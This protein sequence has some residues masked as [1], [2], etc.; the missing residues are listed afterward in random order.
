MDKSL[1]IAV[2]SKE[3]WDRFRMIIGPYLPLMTYSVAAVQLHQSG[4]SVDF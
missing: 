3:K 4:P 1:S 2:I